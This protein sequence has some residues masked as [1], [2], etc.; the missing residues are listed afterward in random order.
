[1]ATSAKATINRGVTPELDEIRLPL[2]FLVQKTVRP[3]N[4][5]GL[6]RVI[7]CRLRHAVSERG[8]IPAEQR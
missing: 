4:P 8:L 6:V 2:R 7:N 1:M 5:F 3:P